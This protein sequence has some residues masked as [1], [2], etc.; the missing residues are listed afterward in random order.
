MPAHYPD[1]ENLRDSRLSRDEVADLAQTPVRDKTDAQVAAELEVHR[2]RAD[3][4]AITPDDR[5]PVPT[6]LHD[7]HLVDALGSPEYTKAWQ[8]R[9]YGLPV[10]TEAGNR[11]ALILAEFGRLYP[12]RAYVLYC[13]FQ[14]EWTDA[15]IGEACGYSERTAKRIWFSSL[16]WVQQRYEELYHARLGG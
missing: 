5:T 2:L 6:E 4:S 8:L 1:P 13:K 7:R 14:R 9:L 11:L 15:A 16:V 3:T 10:T 12:G